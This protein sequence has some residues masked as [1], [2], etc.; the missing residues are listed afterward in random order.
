M[1]LTTVEANANKVRL[2]G[3]N[4]TAVWTVQPVEPTTGAVGVAYVPWQRF[5]PMTPIPSR[6]PD[7]GVLAVFRGEPVG[8]TEKYRWHKRT[9]IAVIV[10][11]WAYGTKFPAWAREPVRLG[12]IGLM[13]LSM[14]S[15]LRRLV[16]PSSGGSVRLGDAGRRLDGAAT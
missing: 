1:T 10:Q 2:C 12:R 4:D 3:C 16:E 9:G 8:A 7:G 13:A 5:T 14:E 15:F 6:D 11:G